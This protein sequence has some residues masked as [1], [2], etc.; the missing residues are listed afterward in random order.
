MTDLKSATCHEIPYLFLYI[1]YFLIHFSEK[2]LKKNSKWKW[3]MAK[4][5]PLKGGLACLRAISLEE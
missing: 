5:T 2:N 3:Q 1:H 4:G